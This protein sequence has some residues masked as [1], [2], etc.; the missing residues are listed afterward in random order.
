MEWANEGNLKDYLTKN[1]QRLTWLQKIQLAKGI[2]QGL[3][4]L[5]DRQMFHRDLVC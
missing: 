3:K 5:H 1:V 2:A 4:W